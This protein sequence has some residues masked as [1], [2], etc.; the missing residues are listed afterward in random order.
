MKE[1]RE[2]LDQPKISRLQVTVVCICMLM[3]ML[4]G[5]D[6]MVI[7]YAAPPL[8]DAWAITPGTLGTVFSAG[9]LGMTLGAM[10]LAP[11]ADRIGR[12]RMIMTCIV[13]MGAGTLV[14]AYAQNV[15]QLILL[16]LASGLGIGAMLA[17]S[18]TMGAEYVPKRM[19]NLG[20]SVV[21][22]GYPAGAVL[23]GLVAAFIIPNYGWQS[24]FIFAGVVT[25]VTLI[26]VAVLLPESLEFLIKERGKNALDSVN[27]I[28]RRMNADPLPELPPEA[29]GEEIKRASVKALFSPGRRSATT[30]LWIAFF[31]SFATLYF[32]TSWI[33]KL[34]SNTGLSLELAIYA[35]TVFN[36]GAFFGII[37]QG[38]FSHHFGLRRTISSFL[39]GTAILMVLFGYWQQPWI[40]LLMFGLIGFGVQ[41]G[42]VG[43]YA[44]AA[45]LYPMEIRNT[46]IGWG[47]GAGRTGAIVGPKIGGTLVGMGLSMTAN[48]MVFA[49]PLVVAAIATIRV[50]SKGEG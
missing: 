40:I 27:R 50:G 45:W 34:A 4:D 18:A 28:L 49:V 37:T 11:F 19:K 3:N 30:W 5:M 24:I 47:I 8:A 10:F 48:F 32:L 13:L 38:T 25:L 33:P 15:T 21:F 17:T 44:V 7:A 29:A 39:I 31:T 20:V 46:G 22:A 2:Y 9:L 42:F 14:T 43:L 1:I 26:P 16:R 23:S 6:V 36:L 35:G 41:G 12:R